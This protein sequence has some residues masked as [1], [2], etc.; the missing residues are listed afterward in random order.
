MFK[1][2]CLKTLDVLKVVSSTDW[3]ADKSI[4]AEFVSVAGQI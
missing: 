2:R 3:G 4:F 1:A